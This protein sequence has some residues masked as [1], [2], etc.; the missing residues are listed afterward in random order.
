MLSVLRSPSARRTSKRRWPN[1]RQ[2]APGAAET[3][4]TQREQEALAATARAEQATE[5][6]RA[7][8]LDLQR[9]SKWATSLERA[10]RKARQR[11]AQ[12]LK[13]ERALRARE[14]ER[15]KRLE[16]ERQRL[17]TELR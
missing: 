4:V 12:A 7:S 16:R 3:A 15:V 8:Q 9:E 2:I 5:E 13:R 10:E 11:M 1:G 6:L 17:I 14:R